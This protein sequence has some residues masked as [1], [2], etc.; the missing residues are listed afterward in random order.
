[1]LQP[2]LQ[3]CGEFAD[4]LLGGPG[5]TPLC[6]HIPRNDAVK[7]LTDE[8]INR[9]RAMNVGMAVTTPRACGFSG[10]IFR[11]NI[12]TSTS[13]AVLFWSNASPGP[14]QRKRDLTVSPLCLTTRPILEDPTGVTGLPVRCGKNCSFPRQFAISKG[15]SLHR[16]EFIAIQANQGENSERTRGT[17]RTACPNYKGATFQEA[18]PL[19]SPTESNG[20]QALITL[21]TTVASPG[22][23]KRRTRR[24]DSGWG[25]RVSSLPST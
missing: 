14:R 17:L 11:R 10:T 12:C 2:G 21:A 5:T 19:C 20:S 18:A 1:V 9:F 4:P 16:R 8:L 15:L 24:W 22:T 25:M 6:Y 13:E 3:S 7:R 23:L